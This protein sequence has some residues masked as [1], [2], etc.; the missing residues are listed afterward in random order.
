MTARIRT[1]YLPGDGPTAVLHRTRKNPARIAARL[2]M[3]SIAE[4]MH[5]NHGP[6]LRHADPVAY[7][8]LVTSMCDQRAALCLAIGVPVENVD[9]DGYNVSRSGPRK[10]GAR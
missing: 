2:A 1:A 4:R 5:P 8:N 3:S 6:A 9:R 10:A 7:A